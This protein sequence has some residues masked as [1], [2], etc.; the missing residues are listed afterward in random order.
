M[1]S[2]ISL[3]D[4]I[5]STLL[6][7][8]PNIA[9]ILIVMGGIIYGISYLQPA[10]ARGRWQSLAMGIVIGGIIVAAITGAAELIAKSSA[11]ML[12]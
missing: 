3:V 12:T 4:S 10:Q 7:L 8:G 11:T 6:E 2:I 5:K 1:A 9:I